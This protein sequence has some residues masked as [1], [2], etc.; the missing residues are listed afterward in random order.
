M[1]GE[2]HQGSRA[3]GR[4]RAAGHGPG[5]WGRWHL[6]GVLEELPRWSRGQDSALP[7][8]GGWVRSL[9]GETDPISCN[10][11]RR[12]CVLLLTPDAAK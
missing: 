11:D 3:S 1:S 10:E 4:S 5:A 12:S 8:Q 9:V 2:E 6:N 7:T